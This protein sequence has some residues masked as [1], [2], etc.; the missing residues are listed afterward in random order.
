MKA[1]RGKPM[2]LLSK[3]EWDFLAGDISW[4]DYKN[5]PT[6]VVRMWM[7]QKKLMRYTNRKSR[8]AGMQML[9]QQDR[10]STREIIKEL[11][12]GDS[13]LQEVI[14]KAKEE[15]RFMRGASRIS[16]GALGASGGGSSEDR[17]EIG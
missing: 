9:R 3:E 16:D 15:V 12:M 1:I 10:K 8:G 14:E 2:P 6:Q 7:F 5:A 17:D 11:A 13:M 4:K